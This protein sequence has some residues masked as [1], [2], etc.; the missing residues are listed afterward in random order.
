LILKLV[1][2]LVSPTL[3]G[4]PSWP[5]GQSVRCRYEGQVILSLLDEHGLSASV[6]QRGNCCNIDYPECGGSKY[7]QVCEQQPQPRTPRRQR[8]LPGNLRASSGPWS[9]H[10]P[11][12]SPTTP[13][14]PSRH[15]LPASN[16]LSA[17][18]LPWP[19]SIHSHYEP[20]TEQS[21]RPTPPSSHADPKKTDR[22]IVVLNSLIRLVAM[23]SCCY[24]SCTTGAQG[25]CKGVAKARKDYTAER[26]VLRSTYFYVVPCHY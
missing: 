17:W 16:P 1:K 6:N 3:S 9:V 2:S 22:P 24:T 23:I 12:R 13:E 21:R 8:P 19:G 26:Y 15:P 11:T 10:V 25:C 20:R 14:L 5:R 4:P 18:F 7:A